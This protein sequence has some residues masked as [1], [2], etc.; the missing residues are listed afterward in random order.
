MLHTKKD[1]KKHYKISEMHNFRSIFQDSI[2][3]MQYGLQSLNPSRQ[4]YQHTVLYTRSHIYCLISLF[5]CKI[6]LVAVSSLPL[7]L[8]N[9]L[10]ILVE[11]A[12]AIYRQSINVNSNKINLTNCPQKNDWHLLFTAFWHSGFHIFVC[13]RVWL[14]NKNV[15]N[16]NSIKRF[17]SN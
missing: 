10:R 4:Q 2:V 16:R 5:S 15:N 3:I 1:I 17:D 8:H 11:Y 14:C 6:E 9:L 7:W 12:L 13:V